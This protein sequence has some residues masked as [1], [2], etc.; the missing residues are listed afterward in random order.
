MT[1]GFLV[2]VHSG[3]IINPRDV[4]SVWRFRVS[5]S[6]GSVIPIPEKKYT[7]VKALLLENK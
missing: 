5:L 4:V 7:A 1:Q 3:Y 6:D 2:R